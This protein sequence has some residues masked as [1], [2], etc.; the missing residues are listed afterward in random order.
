MR[1]I[2]KLFRDTETDELRAVTVEQQ[3]DGRIMLSVDGTF[4]RTELM[5][6]VT[7]MTWLT[8]ALNEF[9]EVKA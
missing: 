2:E 1:K 6:N 7:T 9:F 4:K 8:T 3:P 5:G